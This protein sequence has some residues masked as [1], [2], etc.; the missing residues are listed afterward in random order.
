VSHN[1][2]FT[3]L[4]RDSNSNHLKERSTLLWIIAVFHKALQS[5]KGKQTTVN[6]GVDIPV[7][8]PDNGI[9]HVGC[10]RDVTLSCTLIG[11][12]LI[13]NRGR[14]ACCRW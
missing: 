11:S 2:F 1:A 5:S 14:A 13:Q 6:Q 10:L 3:E 9:P 12:Q 7:T 8:K 4:N